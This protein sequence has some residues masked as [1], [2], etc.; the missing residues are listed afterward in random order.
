MWRQMT[1]PETIPGGLPL[2]LQACS[3]R[4]NAAML[5]KLMCALLVGARMPLLNL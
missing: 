1:T 5:Y 2:S 3:E 4:T